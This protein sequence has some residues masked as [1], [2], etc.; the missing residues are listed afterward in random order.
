LV[1]AMRA[2]AALRVELVKREP[3]NSTATPFEAVAVEPEQVI[4]VIVCGTVVAC[5]R[6]SFRHATVHL[7][8]GGTVDARR[9]YAFELVG[10]DG[11]PSGL[12]LMRQE[13]VAGFVVSVSQ[14]PER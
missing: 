3:R 9:G 14:E 6:G 4:G 13:E 8:R 2:D 1:L 5:I 11:A 7:R 10:P 12:A